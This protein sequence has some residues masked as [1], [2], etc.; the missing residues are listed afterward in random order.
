MKSLIALSFLLSTS[1]F[2]NI[3]CEGA[4]RLAVGDG[5]LITNAMN[6]L[7]VSSKMVMTWLDREEGNLGNIKAACEAGD[8]LSVLCKKLPE[9]MANRESGIFWNIS[10][11]DKE[12][13]KVRSRNKVIAKKVAVL[14]K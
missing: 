5:E 11:T 2:A 12:K 6:R 10:G 3:T 9:I 1:A 14:C 13:E 4:I 8:D 7:P